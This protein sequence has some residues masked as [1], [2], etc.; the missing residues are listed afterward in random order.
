M[1]NKKIAYIYIVIWQTLIH[2]WEMTTA[3]V[4]VLL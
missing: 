3:I 1:E 2:T 4:Q